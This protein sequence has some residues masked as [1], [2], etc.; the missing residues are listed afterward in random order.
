MRSGREG[1]A[2]TGDVTVAE[3]IDE[4]D[5]DVGLAGFSNCHGG[6]GEKSDDDTI[7]HISGTIDTAPDKSISQG[8]KIGPAHEYHHPAQDVS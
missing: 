6:E 7:R 3:V 5:D 8:F 1:I 4:E 2:E